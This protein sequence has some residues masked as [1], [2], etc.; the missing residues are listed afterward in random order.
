M[1]FWLTAQNVEYL[2]SAVI[3]KMQQASQR[4]DFRNCHNP[5]LLHKYRGNTHQFI[6]Q[7][8]QS[9][10]AQAM[11]A[12]VSKELAVTFVISA[13]TRSGKTPSRVKQQS[14]WER[15][16]KW[17]V[18]LLHQQE[19]DWQGGRGRE[20]ERVRQTGRESKMQHWRNCSKIEATLKSN[21]IL[22]WSTDFSWKLKAFLKET[23]M[24]CLQRLQTPLQRCE[25]IWEMQHKRRATFY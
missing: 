7:V 14:E 1:F 5:F 16:S 24:C 22:H 11:A 13:L 6:Q 20:R 17:K 8:F 19:W 25:L 18:F 10:G 3:S 15:E 23:A 2:F 12:S 9:A 4:E 21:H